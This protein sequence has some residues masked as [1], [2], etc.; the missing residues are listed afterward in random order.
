VPTEGGAVA[1]VP[2]PVPVSLQLSPETVTLIGQA[3]NALGRLQGIAGQ[4]FNPYLI[5]SPLLHREAILSSKM[6][7]TI[8]TPKRLALLQADPTETALE[9]SDANETREVLN[10]MSAMRH[11]LG[12]LGKLPVCLR[13]IRELHG[14]LMRDVR[15]GDERPGEFRTSQNW[16]G[17]GGGRSIDTAR[18][19]PPPVPEMQ[20]ALEDFENYLNAS[21]PDPTL[22]RLALGHYQFEAIHP[23]RDGNGRVGRLLIPLVLCDRGR[24]ESPL[25]YLSAYL[26]RNRDDYV[27]HLLLV[28]QTGRWEPWVKF[29]IRAVRESAEESIAQAKGLLKLRRDYMEMF[30]TSRSSALLVKLID[31]LFAVP[32]INIK[33][34]ARLLDVTHQAA[35]GNI[36]KLVGAGILREATGRRRNQVFLADGILDFMSQS[37]DGDGTPG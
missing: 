18:F 13:L 29:F 11:G 10:Y 2:D 27:D 31:H 8:T 5:G 21:T 35:A 9:E 16:I 24:L 25:L 32:S 28:S 12:R 22:V 3:E 37:T 17:G 23:F 36:R 15:G 30:Q 7:G 20:K 4:D 6:E 26:E 1:F 33:F 34:A 19:V 14:V